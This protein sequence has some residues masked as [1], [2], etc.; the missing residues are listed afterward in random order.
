MPVQTKYLR[1]RTPAVL[2]DR[3]G[4]WRVCWLGGWDK[5]R[6]FFIVM[7]ERGYADKHR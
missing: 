5:C 1:L 7:I 6:V 4:A 2:G 3:I